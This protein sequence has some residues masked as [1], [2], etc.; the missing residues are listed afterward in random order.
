MGDP[1]TKLKRGLTL[2]LIIFYGVGTILGSGIY[3]LVGKVAEE[4]GIYAPLSFL[5]ASVIALFSGL[6]YAELSSRFPEAAGEVTYVQKAFYLKWLSIV[7]GFAIVLSSILST[8]T[9]F[10]GFVGY[11]NEFISLP[12]IW[13]ISA[14][15]VLLTGFAIWGIVQS[16]WLIL[17]ITLIEVGGILLF[18]FVG[19]EF[20]IDNPTISKQVFS[21]ESFSHW[22]AILSG[23]FIAFFAFIGFEDLV[24]EAEET[25]NPRRNIP[26]AIITSMILMTVLYT[27][28][29][30]IA[31]AALPIEQL[32]E[33][34][35]PLADVLKLKDTSLAYA[36]SLIGL[37]ASIN[38]STVQFILGSRILYGMSKKGM[39]PELF[40]KVH[41]KTQTPI[42]ATLIV[43]CC[44][45]VIAWKFIIKDLAE[46]T[47]FVLVAVFILINL[48]L[49]V[50]K[51]KRFLPH[52]GVSYPLW[53][54]IAG[55]F[56]SLAF[57][58]TYILN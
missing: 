19:G 16:A 45:F 39:I 47:D 11:L 52:K 23:A 13:T 17:I 18:I 33:S 40:G 5:V 44:T 34:S 3:V 50:I 41:H 46:Y 57:L 30:F 49:W 4:A 2:P 55:F 15:S 27:I 6:S 38:G 31:V 28:V 42:I 10:N 24:N 29:S 8:A 37:V 54:P 35:A 32:S 14:L 20:L 9:V 21:M 48:S 53:V 7:V 22:K 58:M 12:K 25:V 56:L 1:N 36:I 51:K 26:I 43:A